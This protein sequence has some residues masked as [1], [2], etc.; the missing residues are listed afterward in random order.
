MGK[1]A[2]VGL[3]PPSGANSDICLLN[4]AVGNVGRSGPS[5]GNKSTSP[6]PLPRLALPWL[7]VSELPSSPHADMRYEAPASTTYPTWVWLM[8]APELRLSPLP[9]EAHTSRLQPSHSGG[10]W[11]SVPSLP[12]RLLQHVTECLESTEKQDRKKK[13]ETISSLQ[14]ARVGHTNFLSIVAFPS[15]TFLVESDQYCP[16]YFL[17]LSPL[18]IV[19]QTPSGHRVQ[20][21]QFLFI[22]HSRVQGNILLAISLLF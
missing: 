19:T 18:K 1:G 7:Y 8:F 22:H 10:Y 4:S 17:S 5:P 16:W 13:L 2:V 14:P 6:S 20:L 3:F 9:S 11:F 15:W 12:P 21:P